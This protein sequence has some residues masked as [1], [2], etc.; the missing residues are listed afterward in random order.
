M[1]RYSMEVV[2]LITA[3]LLCIAIPLTAVGMAVDLL[4]N[5]LRGKRGSRVAAPDGASRVRISSAFKN[6]AQE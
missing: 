1:L 4:R 3:V 6:L 5:M 2:G